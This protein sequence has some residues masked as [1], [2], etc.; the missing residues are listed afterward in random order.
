MPYSWD[1]PSLPHF[2]ALQVQGATE[3]KEV[4]LMQ[5]GQLGKLYY[6]S[7]VYIAATATFV[8]W[9][10]EQCGNPV[11]LYVFLPQ[12]LWTVFNIW[13]SERFSRVPRVRP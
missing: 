4:S 5:F 10:S 12:Q 7:Y 13:I 1:E 6:E 9:Y 3:A 2:L 11:S 8:K